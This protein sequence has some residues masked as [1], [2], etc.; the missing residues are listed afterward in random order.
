MYY[1]KRCIYVFVSVLICYLIG[2]DL[3]VAM[4]LLSKYLSIKDFFGVG[5]VMIKKNAF[6]K[7][8]VLA[9]LFL[10]ASG[11][12]LAQAANNAA[13]KSQE[14]SEG[15]GI[16][17]LIKHLPD[18]ENA[19]KRAAYIFN[20]SDLQNA[21]GNRPLL[22]SIDFQGGTEAVTAPYPQG[23]LLI[24]EFASPQSSVE[25]DTQI[26]QKLAEAGENSS[27]VYR[28]TGNYNIFV[29]DADDEAAANAL[30]EQVKYE[31]TVQWLGTDP[32]AVLRAE[33][34]YL[35]NTASLFLSTVKAI[36]GGIGLSLLAGLIVGIIFFY[37]RNQKRANM[38]AFS[39][40]GGLTRLNL[41]E[42]TPSILPEKFLK[43]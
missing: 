16:P 8:L 5:F 17:V 15:D 13:I 28:R 33:R 7:F 22:D 43:D 39:D 9:A 6:G 11:G 18:W 3:I 29:F 20:K 10:S 25:A 14:V 31:K 24:V 40:A 1:L 35:N 27:A 4:Q 19:Q 12:V 37:V 2:Y 30:I 34:A 38:Q 32:Y 36:A 41:D 21:L 42:L 23:R 26:N